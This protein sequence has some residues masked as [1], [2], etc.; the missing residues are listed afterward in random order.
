SPGQRRPRDP[1]SPAP[2]AP[3]ANPHRRRVLLLNAT[4]EPLTALPL[5]RAIVLVVCGKAEVVH[6]DPT[7]LTLHS[8]T[9]TVEVPSVIRL[10]SYVRVPYRAQVPLT[11]AGLMHRDRFRCAYCGAR[12]ETVDHVVP[13]SRG[14]AHSWQNCVACCTRCNHRKADRSLA[15]LGWQ[16]RVVPHAPRG[17]HWRLLAHAGEADSLWRR[18]LGSA[19]A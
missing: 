17:Q 15:E 14:G 10:G 1:G 13:R 12:A 4:F 5:R 2:S 19:A 6:E 18:Y 9:M 11:R 16:L 3:P 7:G 8:A